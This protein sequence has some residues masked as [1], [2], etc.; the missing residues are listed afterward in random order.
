VWL[1]RGCL[2]CLVCFVRSLPPFARWR[3]V[4]RGPPPGAAETRSSHGLFQKCNL[5][6]GI[7]VRECGTVPD[8]ESNMG[9]GQERLV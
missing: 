2:T 5:E 3:R 7:S 4:A 9:S 6:I 1:F 8:R